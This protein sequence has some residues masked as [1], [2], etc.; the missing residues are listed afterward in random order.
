MHRLILEFTDLATV[1]Y[2]MDNLEEMLLTIQT[3]E[4]LPGDFEISFYPDEFDMSWDVEVG[5]DE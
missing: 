2:F 3:E 5:G 4:D 1:S